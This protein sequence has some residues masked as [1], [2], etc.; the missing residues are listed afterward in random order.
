MYVFF[1]HRSRTSKFLLFCAPFF[2]ILPKKLPKFQENEAAQKDL[3]ENADLSP[4]SARRMIKLARINNYTLNNHYSV[5]SS[6]RSRNQGNLAD[7]LEHEFFMV[8]RWIKQ[9]EM[10]KRAPDPD[11]MH[12]ELNR[13]IDAMVDHIDKFNITEKKRRE[14]FHLCQQMSENSMQKYDNYFVKCVA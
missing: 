14:I 11:T 8:N 9:L 7:I 5:S 4:T 2:S 10:A 13:L 1:V 3:M 12:G 6:D